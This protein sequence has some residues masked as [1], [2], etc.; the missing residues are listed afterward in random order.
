ME[1]AGISPEMRA[2]NEGK[3]HAYYS[4]D[5]PLSSVQDNNTRVKLGLQVVTFPIYP[6]TAPILGDPRTLPPA[7]GVRHEFKNA[8]GHWISGGGHS[9]PPLVEAIE[10]QKEED[11][12][13]LRQFV[14]LP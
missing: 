9:I 8:G 7:I 4:D 14:P 3:I 12:T 2:A 13:A 10:K 11:I 5:D 1:R 6:V